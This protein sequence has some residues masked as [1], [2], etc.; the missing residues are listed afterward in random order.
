MSKSRLRAG[1]QPCLTDTLHRSKKPPAIDSYGRL[2]PVFF[3]SLDLPLLNHNQAVLNRVFHACRAG[4][5]NDI[6]KVATFPRSRD[7]GFYGQPNIARVDSRFP[8]RTMI[9]RELMLI[10]SDM[11]YNYKLCTINLWSNLKITTDRSR[12]RAEPS[13]GTHRS[14]WNAGK[15][16]PIETSRLMKPDNCE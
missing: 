13:G 1:R 4:R 7:R 10:K 8:A 9:H 5:R 2:L 11:T 16:A 15:G 12:L 14:C 6:I 3:V